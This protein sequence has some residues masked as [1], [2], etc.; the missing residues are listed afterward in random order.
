MQCYRVSLHV[1]LIIV[2]A[3]HEMNDMTDRGQGLNNAMKDSSE[4]VDA[5][6]AVFLERRP[7][8][9]AIGTYEAEMIPRGATEVRLSR[10]LAEKRTDARYVDDVVRLGLHQPKARV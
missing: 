4:I 10:E 9:D 5:L 7:L 6:T 3:N 1:N 8:K 2:M